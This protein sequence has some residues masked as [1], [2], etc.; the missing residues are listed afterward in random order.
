MRLRYLLLSLLVTGCIGRGS[1]SSAAAHD[2]PITVKGPEITVSAPEKKNY[3]QGDEFKTGFRSS[4]R[5]D[6]VKLVSADKSLKITLLRKD[7]VSGEWSVKT[8]ER[9]KVGNV[10]YRFNI[11]NDGNLYSRAAT[12]NLKPKTAPQKQKAVIEKV[13][14]IDNY[15][16]QGFE[17]VGDTAYFSSGVYG[18]SFVEAVNLPTR[19]V[20][21]VQDMDKR[22]FAEGLTVLDDKVYVLTWESKKCMIYGR[23]TLQKIREQDY[24]YAEGWGLTND[25]RYLYMSDGSKYIYKLNP[26]TFKELNRIE[27]TDNDGPVEYINELEWVDGEIWANVFTY[28]YILRIDP[29]TG[30]VKGIIDCSDLVRQVTP[31]SS[32]DFLNGIAYDKDRNIIYLSGKNWKKIFKVSIRNM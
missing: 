4:I 2:E 27:V 17:M 10:Q 26:E 9:S 30:V 28:N 1:Q 22:Y 14:P 21:R 19:K 23:R 24:P 13:I 25:G 11:Y 31:T 3:V 8:S 29:D 12:Y 5:V 32:E 15:F 18:K 20:L 16:L 6:S 7:S